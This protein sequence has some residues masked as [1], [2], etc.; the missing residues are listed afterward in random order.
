MR[1]RAIGECSCWQ[2][3]YLSCWPRPAKSQTP[4]PRNTLHKRKNLRVEQMDYVQASTGMYE[5]QEKEKWSACNQR[6][7]TEEQVGETSGESLSNNS[8]DW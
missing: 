7:V 5:R 8:Q 2:A 3:A 1:V 4:K 6:S